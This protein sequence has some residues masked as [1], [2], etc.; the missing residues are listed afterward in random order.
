MRTILNQRTPAL[1]AVLAF[2]LVWSANAQLVAD[3]ATNT[4]NGTNVNLGSADLIVGTNLPNTLLVI[5]NGGTLTDGAGFIGFNAGANSNAVIVTGPNSAWNNSSTLIV[6]SNGSFNTLLISNGGV[7]RNLSATLGVNAGANSNL[8]RVT[9]AGSLWSIAGNLKIGPN[10]FGNTLIISDGGKVTDET[11]NVGLGSSKNNSVLVTGNGSVWSNRVNLNVGAN[12]VGEGALTVADGAAVFSSGATIGINSSAASNTVLVTGSGSV[13]RNEGATYGDGLLFVGYNASNNSLI[14]NN[15]GA[16]FNSSTA[17]IGESGNGNRVVITDPGSVWNNYGKLFIGNAGAFNQLVVS[18]GG[19]MVNY[20]LTYVGSNTTAN[21][22]TILVTSPHSLWSNSY[23]LVIGTYGS[24]NQLIVSNGGTVANTTGHVGSQS[25]SMSNFVCVTGTGSLWT[26]SDQ[27]AIG[28]EG[29]FNQLLINNGGGVANTVGV[30]G[31]ESG[32]SNNVVVV[33]GAGSFWTSSGDLNVG[34][35]GSGNQL[36]VSNGGVV[37]NGF[38]FIGAAAGANDNFALI[39]GAGS[40]WANNNDLYVGNFGSGNQMVVSHGGAVANSIGLLGWDIGASNNVVVVTDAGSLW[41]NN[42]G[43]L[44][45]GYSGTGNQLVVSN[46]GVVVSGYGSG[47]LG[48]NAGA[49]NNVA[50]VTGAGSL[51]DN[52]GYT[53][54]D[55]NLYVGGG[56]SG[57]QLVVS[58]GGVVVSGYGYVGVQSSASNNVAVVTGAGSLWTNTGNLYVG[59]AGSGNLLSVNDGGVVAN[60]TGSIGQFSDWNVAVVTGAGSLWSNS[61]GL[62]IGYQ[63]SGNQLVVSNGGLVTTDYGHLGYY[64]GANNNMALVTGTNSLWTNSNDLNVGYNGIG[65]QLVVGSGGVVQ[66][67]SAIVGVTAGATN[68]VLRL[69]DGTLT[70]SSGLVINANNLLA[71]S[72][73]INGSVTN[74]GTLAPGNST[75]SLTINGSLS[76]AASAGMSFEIGGLIATNQYDRVDV[77]NFVQFAGTLSLSLLNGFLP[78]ST[79]S[80]TLMTFATSTGFFTNAPSSGAV[81]QTT[82][83]LRKFTV[84]YTPTSLVLT[85][86][87][88]G[89]NFILT[90]ILPA[91]NQVTV[92]F[93]STPANQYEIQYSSTLTNWSVATN[94]VAD[95]VTNTPGITTWIDKG[96]NTSGLPL[97]PVRFYRVRQL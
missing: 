78:A 59:G 11:G 51:W 77:T 79:D 52:N 18:N 76:L 94:A 92:S 68:N 4:I 31:N 29:S 44:Y 7:V 38:G 32:A 97:P 84:L 35:Y 87:L 40:L 65:N 49:N 64:T 69:A 13:W 43:G 86:A 85:N 30:V 2:F 83:G 72:G 96:T 33:T 3:G 55:G 70:V 48:Y 67:S 34:L 19:M 23:S 26:N 46:G 73:T 54:V 75:G 16:L 10:G 93:Q 80:F 27:L 47:W 37:A 71:G 39:T 50:V 45:V 28:N 12:G 66:A 6:G 62:Y 58:N 17:V 20:Y 22:N 74:F 14:L 5:T 25:G 8:V 89:T 88:Q 1:A 63:A 15:G 24:F 41:T 82:D 56:G 57:N 81:L 53:G 36:V 61:D 9:G 90:S 95:F 21:S 60:Y 42:I 91:A